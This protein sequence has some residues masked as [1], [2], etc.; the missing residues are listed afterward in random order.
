[1]S[2]EKK[3]WSDVVGVDDKDFHEAR[4]AS[5]LGPS[6]SG[7]SLELMIPHDDPIGVPSNSNLITIAA[8]GRRTGNELIKVPDNVYIISPFVWMIYHGL[9][10]IGK[11]VEKIKLKHV[12][13]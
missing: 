12:I 10:I 8:H 3:D 6:Y 9:G 7:S 11:V 5:N 13:N 4:S 2:G 1:M